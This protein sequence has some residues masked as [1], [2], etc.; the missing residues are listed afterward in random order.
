M[1]EKTFTLKSGREVTL[2]E[3]EQIIL[4]RMRDEDGTEYYMSFNGTVDSY[5]RYCP[6]D[7]GEPMVLKG[8]TEAIRSS[9]TDLVHGMKITDDGC[10]VLA[11]M[12]RKAV[13]NE[14]AE[15]SQDELIDLAADLADLILEFPEAANPAQVKRLAEAVVTLQDRQKIMA[16]ARARIGEYLRQ[17]QMAHVS[18][19]KNKSYT[20]SK[21]EKV[22]AEP[23]SNILDDVR[24][25]MYAKR[26]NLLFSDV[27]LFAPVTVR[28]TKAE[29]MA[30]QQKRLA[31][32]LE[33]NKLSEKQIAVLEEVAEGN[34]SYSS[35]G[36][37]HWR[38][39]RLDGRTFDSL[40]KRGLIDTVS[41]PGF[42][43]DSHYCIKRPKDE[44]YQS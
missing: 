31:Y 28:D 44:G 35:Y 30:V 42:D 24:E 29:F 41:A 16:P 18:Q 20:R 10:E 34:V 43:R 21:S 11:Q 39:K 7:Q 12:R 19:E 2:S 14:F 40:K 17:K 22:M 25:D 32:V 9:V 38:G 4:E 33:H 6:R 37:L 36:G 5:T 13:G 3:N 15:L 23:M 1:S 26:A 8:I 27:A